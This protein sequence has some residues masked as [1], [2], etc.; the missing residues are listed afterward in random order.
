MGKLGGTAVAFLPGVALCKRLMGAGGPSCTSGGRSFIAKGGE[1][2]RWL[3]SITILGF[4]INLT[5]FLVKFVAP[6]PVNLGPWVFHFILSG[7][8]WRLSH[9]IPFFFPI[10]DFLHLV[11]NNHG[12]LVIFFF[13]SFFLSF[14]IFF[15][16]PKVHLDYL[17]PIPSI[18]PSH[19]SVSHIALNDLNRPEIDLSRPPM[20]S[21]DLQWTPITSNDLQFSQSA[22][23]LLATCA[24]APCISC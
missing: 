24:A 11:G 9:K 13:P 16:A 5:S 14:Y 2:Q 20:I 18:Y 3:L 23:V 7:K 6:R 1:N 12:V 19:P 10:C 15:L 8:V 17:L 22:A 21:N 4:K